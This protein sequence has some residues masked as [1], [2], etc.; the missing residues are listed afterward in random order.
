MFTSPQFVASF[1]TAV[2]SEVGAELFFD[3]ISTAYEHL[4]VV[5]TTNLPFENW[6]EVLGSERLNIARSHV[7]R[8]AEQTEHFIEVDVSREL[9]HH[10]PEE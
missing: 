6:T 10:L 5:I 2:S 3:V 4:S 8:Y 9:E 7:E 1:E